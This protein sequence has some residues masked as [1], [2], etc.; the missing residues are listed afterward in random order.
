M[1]YPDPLDRPGRSDKGRRLRNTSFGCRIVREATLGISHD[2][3]ALNDARATEL[4][5]LM[6]QAGKVELPPVLLMR[7]RELLPVP[8]SSATRCPGC[9]GNLRIM[10]GMACCARC[11]L[12][13]CDPGTEPRVDKAG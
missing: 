9:Q 1:R 2:D 7:D 5:A 11:G 12:V 13:W 4:L 6:H 3:I 10:S 8:V